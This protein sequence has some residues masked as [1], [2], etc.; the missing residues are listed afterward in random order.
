MKMH[1]N[2]RALSALFLLMSLLISAFCVTVSATPPIDDG[3]NGVQWIYVNADHTK[4]SGD[5]VT[6]EQVD[7]PAEWQLLKLIGKKYIYMNSPRGYATGSEQT[8]ET[9]Y[10][11][12]KGGYLVYV[13]DHANDEVAIYCESGKMATLQAYFNGTEGKYVIRNVYDNPQEFTPRDEYYDITDSFAEEI[14]SLTQKGKGEKVDVTDLKD[15]PLFE[16]RF[17]DDSGLLSTLRGAIYEMHDGSFGYVDYAA[18]DNSHF[19]AD[20]NF[21]Y[22]RGE[23][24]VYTI[25]DFPS[26]LKRNSDGSYKVNNSYTYEYHEYENDMGIIGGIGGSDYTDEMAITSFWIIFVLLGYLVPIAPLVIGLV[27]AHSKKM[28]HPRRWYIVTGLAVLWIILAVALTVL[29]LV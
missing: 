18:L 26:E 15:C 21:S 8:G 22:R 19:D 7:L 3:E 2:F 6:Y 29:L 5:G 4:L 27:F 1:K 12:E 25:D 23:V 14:L 10:S 13:M 20:G 28:S 9:V 17:H 24:T 11:Y 16:L